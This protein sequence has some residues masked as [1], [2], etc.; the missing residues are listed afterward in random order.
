MFL[1]CDD[2]EYFK[3]LED[4]ALKE[5]PFTRIQ[6]QYLTE[7]QVEKGDGIKLS[8]WMNSRLA[9]D[10]DILAFTSIQ[11]GIQED[12]TE[13]FNSVDKT[14]FKRINNSEFKEEDL[15][16]DLTQ[17]KSWRVKTQQDSTVEESLLCFKSDGRTDE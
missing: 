11:Y 7:E 16:L 1:N 6:G 8:D 2:T 9:S 14:L 17:F 3:E 13:F 12:E 10:E 5:A 15:E 4:M